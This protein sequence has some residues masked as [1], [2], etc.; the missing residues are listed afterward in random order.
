MLI[1][2]A[3]ASLARSQVSCIFCLFFCFLFS[4]EQDACLHN[5][6][7]GSKPTR[8]IGVWSAKSAAKMLK[9]HSKVSALLLTHVPA[10]V[11]LVSLK[12]IQIQNPLPSSVTLLPKNKKNLNLKAFTCSVSDLACS[13]VATAAARVTASSR[14]RYTRPTGSHDPRGLSAT[15]I[16]LAGAAT[17]TSTPT[18]AGMQK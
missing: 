4:Q 16:L 12:K 18:I 11:C 2:L 7:S 13:R 10:L 9:L 3:A 14:I 6:D 1:F 15:D 5:T 17:V 8:L